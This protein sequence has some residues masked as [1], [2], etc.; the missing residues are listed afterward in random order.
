MIQLQKELIDTF[1]KILYAVAKCDGEVQ[2]EELAIIHQVIDENQWAQEL[3]L[4]FEVER[5]MGT[6]PIELFEESMEVFDRH[7]V[8]V[9]YEQFLDL[10]ENVAEAHGGIVSQERAL[11]DQ[12]RKRLLG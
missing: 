12:F 2:E 5:E 7:D 4:S 1:G 11:I 8:R 9:H 3:E 10:L 6:D